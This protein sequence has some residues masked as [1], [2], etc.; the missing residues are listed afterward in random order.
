MI[1]AMIPT[2]RSLLSVHTLF[3][4]LISRM[5]PGEDIKIAIFH[6]GISAL[7]KA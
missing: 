5:T 2:I 7:S 4:R 3:M 6:G 1:P